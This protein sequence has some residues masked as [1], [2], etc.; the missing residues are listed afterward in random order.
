MAMMA[1][2]WVNVDRRILAVALVAACLW[3][4]IP[5]AASDGQGDNDQP[6]VHRA[7]VCIPGGN[8]P[9]PGWLSGE[10]V[11][12]TPDGSTMLFT[13]GP[14]IHAVATDGSRLWQ[15][16]ERPARTPDPGYGVPIGFIAP[17]ALSPDGAELVYAT[18]RYPDPHR[19]AQREAAGEPLV[20]DDFRH[21]LAWVRVDGTQHRRLTTNRDFETDPVWSPDGTRIEFVFREYD[22]GFGYFFS[23]K[24][25]DLYTMA[26]D[27]TDMVQLQSGIH[28]SVSP[29]WSPDSARLVYGGSENGGDGVWLYTVAADGGSPPQRLT[30]AVSGASW[31]PDGRRIAFAKLDG[32]DVAL[33][34]IAADGS[35]AQRVVSITGWQWSYFEPDPDPTRAWIRTVAWSP[36][37]EHILYGCGPAICVVDLESMQVIHA[38]LAPRYSDDVS[39]AAW[40]PNGAR[41]ALFSPAGQLKNRISPSQSIVLYT[42]APN[43]ADIQLLVARRNNHGRYQPID[44]QQMDVSGCARGTGPEVPPTHPNASGRPCDIFQ[45][46]G[47]RHVEAPMDLAGCA[48]GLAVPEPAANPGLVEDCETLLRM[49]DALVGVAN[50]IWDVELNWSVERP[51]VEW[52]GVG[53]DG[54]PPRV[55]ALTLDRR[56]LWGIIPAELGALTQ[57]RVLSLNQNRLIGA[58]PPE[59]GELTQLEQLSLSDNL[60]SGSLPLSLGVLIDLVDMRLDGNYLT[61]PIPAA[62]SGLAQSRSLVL[63]DNYLTGAIPPELGQLANLKTLSVDENR[64]TGSIPASLGRLTSVEWLSLSDNQVTGTIPAELGRLVNLKWLLLHTNQLSGTMPAELEQLTSLEQLHLR[65]NQLTGC[66]PAALDGIPDNDLPS[67]GLPAC[68]PG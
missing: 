49:R 6:D 4:C 23:P 55:T 50:S 64:L 46:I 5:G 21:E 17:F 62:W 45:R 35:D 58:I 37:G 66:I 36:S 29:R 39:M 3:S 57:L 28:P 32:A 53:I 9:R 10:F 54:S 38:P 65:G 8:A 44:S 63:D 20:R 68:Q 15:V 14:Q 47:P 24:P 1:V 60:L 42:M 27:G 22:E 26:P 61:G 40:S 67:L 59:L 25:Y 18:C 30:S 11:R 16:T 31:S 52:E 33:Y 56:D 34:T 2:V 13:D 41:I 48:A 19:A 43:G 7:T 51:L 12:W